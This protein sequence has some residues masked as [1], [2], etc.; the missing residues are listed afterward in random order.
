MPPPADRRYA[1][2]VE[3]VVM[4]RCDIPASAIFTIRRRTARGTRISSRGRPA[5][6]DLDLERLARPHADHPA[7][8]LCD[9]REHVGD[10]LPGRRREVEAEV[11]RDDVEATLAR[12]LK[13][14]SGRRRRCG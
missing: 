12:L 1:V 7:L 5:A 6:G 14:P 10:Q 11:E 4:A 2:S 13:K 3:P 9:R 8:P